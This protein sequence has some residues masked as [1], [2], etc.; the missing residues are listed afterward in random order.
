MSSQD[1]NPPASVF[2]ANQQKVEFCDMGVDLAIKI[3][4]K[5]N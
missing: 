1:R 5:S 4:F 3:D 2:Q